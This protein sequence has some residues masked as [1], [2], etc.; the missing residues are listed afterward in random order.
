[1]LINVEDYRKR[2]EKRLPRSIFDLIDGGAEDEITLK[3]NRAGFE[4][5]SLVPRIL[6]N[7][8]GRDQSVTVLGNRLEV[9]FLLAPTGGAK[10]CWPNGDVL[11]ATG[12]HKCGTIFIVSTYTGSSLE[13]IAE[14]APGKKWFQL[15][16]WR[17]RS[18]VKSLVDRAK[19]A[20][21]EALV[22]TLDYPVP[23]LRERDVRHSLVLP[24]KITFKN[25]LESL[26][27]PLW[28]KRLMFSPSM[29]MGTLAIAPG[30]SGKDLKSTSALIKKNIDPSVTWEDLKWFRSIWS[31]PLVLKGVL[32]PEDARQAASLGIDAIVVSNHGG[33]QLDA[34]ISTI[35]I[36]PEIV[37]AVNGK[38]EILM[39]G[40]IRRG[41]DIIKA[42]ALGA[43]AV[44]IGRP[45]LYGLAANGGPGVD[46]VLNILKTEVDRTMA[47]LGISKLS[48]LNK[49]YFRYHK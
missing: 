45:Y 15:Y 14:R 39:D 42:R 2:A 33:R 24:P 13:E 1:M 11:A 46:A 43:K 9:P 3:R 5:I 19:A 26:L 16:I 48:D 21:Y 6:A 40:G 12:A 37:E 29:S 35:E 30:V 18:L 28:V 34:A 31:G 36:L 4:Q 7:V 23:A 38:T 47:L 22:L 20:G 10:T 44:L 25:A 49:S 17:D 8:E 41:S 27:H 32:S